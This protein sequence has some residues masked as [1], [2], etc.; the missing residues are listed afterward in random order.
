MTKETRILEIGR[1]GSGVAGIHWKLGCWHSFDVGH[2]SFGFQ[3]LREE[4]RAR[5]PG[6]GNR[7][8][9]LSFIGWRRGQGRGGTFCEDAPLLSPLPTPASRGE[10]D[11]ARAQGKNGGMPATRLPSIISAR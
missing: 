10:E 3:R 9:S 7:R 4:I 5:D 8:N 6:R 1:A 11:T 2:S